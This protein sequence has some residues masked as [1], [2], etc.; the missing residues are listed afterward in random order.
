M[1]PG[2]VV[3]VNVMAEDRRKIAG[4]ILAG[5]RSSRMGRNKALLNFNGLPLIDHMTA[6]L[7]KSGFAEVFISGDLDGYTCFPDPDPFA[8]PAQAIIHMMNMLE[9]YEGVLFVPVDMPFITPEI[10][11]TLLS[12]EKGAHYKNWPLPVYFPS[13]SGLDGGRS[14]VRG[15]IAAAG[16]AA[17]TLPEDQQDCFSNINTPEQW[18]EATGI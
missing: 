14:S 17:L 9:G 18:R 15:L 7:R 13:S 6:L 2:Q 8:G 5:G 4:V 10:M 11:Q 1:I 3:A 12:H 16:I